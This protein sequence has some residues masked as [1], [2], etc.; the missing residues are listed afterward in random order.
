MPL[1]KIPQQGDAARLQQLASGLKLEHGTYGAVVQR[2][3]AGRPPGGGV[4]QAAAPQVSELRPEHKMVFDE[5]AQA[6]QSR[7]QWQ[8]LAQQSPTPWVQGMLEIADQ[9]YQRAATRAYNVIPNTEF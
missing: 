3:P 4:Q 1:P 6:E 2:T 9:N 8:A 7:Q 5:L